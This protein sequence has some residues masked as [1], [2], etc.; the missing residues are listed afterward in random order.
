MNVVPFKEQK[1]VSIKK[2]VTTVKDKDG[3][4]VEVTKLLNMK[5]TQESEDGKTVTVEVQ[6]SSS[7][8]IQNNS[9]HQLFLFLEY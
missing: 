6:T 4:I 2:G 7:F 1:S 5:M 9:L 8:Q 3:N